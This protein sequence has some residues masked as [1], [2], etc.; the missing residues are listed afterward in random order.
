MKGKPKKKSLATF[1]I[2]KVR[3]DLR[4]SIWYLTYHEN[5]KRLRPR[6]GADKELA[7]QM[8]DRI[9]SQLESHTHSVFNFEPIGIDELQKRWLNHHEQVLRSSLQTIRRYRAAIN[10]L[11]NFIDQKGTASKTS[12]FQPSHA[13]EFVHYLRT[14]KGNRSRF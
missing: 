13:E 7:R 5:G 10:H 9:N 4:G 3:G 11:I 6:V 14:I 12:Q 1:R 2:G 8:A